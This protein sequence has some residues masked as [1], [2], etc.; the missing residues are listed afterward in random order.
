MGSLH[1]L[2]LGEPAEAEGL[3]VDRLSA[4]IRDELGHAG[5]DRRGDLEAGAA[6]RGGE[7]E[8]IDAAH[9]AQ[10]RVAIGSVAAERALAAGEGG[11]LP[12]R[13]VLGEEQRPEAGAR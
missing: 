3:N 12:G 8:P 4:P 1:R 9:R 7:V 13:E 11:S 5:A 2:A 6:E 10:D